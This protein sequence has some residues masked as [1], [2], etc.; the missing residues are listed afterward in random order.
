MHAYMHL[1]SLQCHNGI[2]PNCSLWLSTSTYG[3][4][5]EWLGDDYTSFS[6]FD[7]AY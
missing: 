5:D 4:C 7:H 1:L 2:R 6:E 3:I